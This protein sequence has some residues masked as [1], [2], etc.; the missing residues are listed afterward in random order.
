M[1]VL[2]TAW[3]AVGAPSRAD[4]VVSGICAR[5][6]CSAE[7]SPARAVVSKSFTGFEGWLDPSGHG[8]CAAC[9]WAYSTDALRLSAHV[10][11]AD[12]PALTT[13]TRTQVGELLGRGPV[14][15][16]CAVVVP[17]RPGRKHLMHAAV[18]SR[19]TID[20]AQ[21]PWGARDAARLRIMAQLRDLGFGTRMLTGTAPP[22]PT[23]RKLPADQW[24]RVVQMWAE[25]D[26][27]R[28]SDSPWLALALHVTI[29]ATD[30]KEKLR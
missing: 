30:P 17:L 9:C 11:T 23:L 25:L 1:T 22:F 4:I 20:D 24:A 2:T 26:P 12:P 14:G 15:V 13:L 10:V 5:C 27:W 29:P 18:W 3:R 7:L 8:L 28:I 6:G 19:V 21:L 16:G